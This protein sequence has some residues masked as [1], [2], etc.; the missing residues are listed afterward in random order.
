M[1]ACKTPPAGDRAP[2]GCLR[3]TGPPPVPKTL[4]FEPVEKNVDKMKEYL[5]DT[6]ASSAF[7]KCPHEPLPMMKCAPIRIHVK[8]DAKP[9]ACKTASTVPLH[10][11]EAVKAQ[12]EEDVALGTI[13]KVPIGVQTTWQARMHVVTKPRTDG[14]PA[15][16]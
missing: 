13:E 8:E 11:R 9:I 10:L 7:N 3:R 15:P 4:P 1:A 6:Y 16:P 12:L 5:L 14:R 2:C